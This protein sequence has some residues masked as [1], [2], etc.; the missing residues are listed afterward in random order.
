ME[1]LRS[2]SKILMIPPVGILL[3]DLIYGWFVMARIKLRTL[4]EVWT[5]FDRSSYNAARPFIESLLTPEGANKFLGWARA[6]IARHF[7]D[8]PLCRLLGLVPPQRREKSR[9]LYLSLQPV[10]SQTRSF[11]LCAAFPAP[12]WCIP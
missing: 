3:Y 11:T 1:A 7:A 10:D 5:A 12:T 8:W 6:V 9:C 4:Q 2:L